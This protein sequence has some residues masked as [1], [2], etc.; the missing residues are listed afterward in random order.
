MMD[1]IWIG[2]RRTTERSG[3]HVSSKQYALIV[4]AIWSLLFCLSSKAF[5]QQR[6]QKNA[7]GPKLLLTATVVDS[8]FC[9]SSTLRLT[10]ELSFN[11]IGSKPILL[12]KD[13]FRVGRYKVSRN[14]EEMRAGK[15]E[16]NVA[17]MMNS[18]GILKYRLEGK[19]ATDD[20]GLM[21]LEPGTTHTVPIELSIPF[22]EA[23]KQGSRNSLSP[24]NHSLEI[25][26]WTWIDSESFATRW[27]EKWRDRGYLWTKSVASE[28]ITFTV[29]QEK[30]I[31]PCP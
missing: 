23:G 15:Y 17:P 11:N 14:A 4:I 30:V 31:S 29:A 24:G 26:V 9:S 1:K 25:L 6:K 20:S 7:P 28:P 16:L 22:I 12:R 13:G 10:L 27:R 5:T 3:K 18:I 2:T 8:A 19:P 21:T